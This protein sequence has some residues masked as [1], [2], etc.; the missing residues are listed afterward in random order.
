MPTV[1][2]QS[3]EHEKISQILKHHGMLYYL[4]LLCYNLLSIAV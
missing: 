3:N 1:A 4:L 2:V